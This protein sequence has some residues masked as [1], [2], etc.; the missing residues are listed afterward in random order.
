MRTVKQVKE[1]LVKAKIKRA[2]L[3][4]AY[5]SANDEI[6]RLECELYTEKDCYESKLLEVQAFQWTGGYKNALLHDWFKCERSAGNVTLNGE[7]WVGDRKVGFS[8]YVFY[9]HGYIGSMSESD[10]LALFRKK[11]EEDEEN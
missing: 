1:D 3:K 6:S 8:D 2:S 7:L 5:F 9:T 11:G 10:F 4:E